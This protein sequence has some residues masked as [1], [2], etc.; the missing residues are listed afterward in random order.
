MEGREMSKRTVRPI[1]V[2]VI[3]STTRPGEL[4]IRAKEGD[5]TA[6]PVFLALNVCGAQPGDWME[7]RLVERRR[8]AKKG[9]RHGTR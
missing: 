7:L 8:T 6:T 9:E 2:L 3:E 5:A 1:P 4:S